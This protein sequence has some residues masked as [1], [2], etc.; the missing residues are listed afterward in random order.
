MANNKDFKVKKGLVVTENILA[1]GNIQLVDSLGNTIT[2]VDS[3]NN[4]VVAGSIIG[5]STLTIDPAAIGDATG[6]VRILGNLQVEGTQTTV[7]STTMTVTDK[8]IEIAKGAANDA[9]ADGAGITVDSG[10]GD[11]TWNW[12]DSTDS[13]TSSEHI[14]L[15]SGKG[16]KLNGT[17]V[18]TPGS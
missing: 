9:A 14:N 4:V 17:T 11:K 13:W 16:I 5:P 7:N 2:L 3:S 8:N 12:V 10:D 1:Q 6:L 15:A 18:L